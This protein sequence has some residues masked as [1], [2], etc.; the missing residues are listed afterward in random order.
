MNQLD[1]E[2]IARG[3][4][5][6]PFNGSA[7]GVFQPLRENFSLLPPVQTPRRQTSNSEHGDSLWKSLEDNNKRGRTEG[8]KESQPDVRMQGAVHETG[9][10]LTNSLNPSGNTALQTQQRQ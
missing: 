5:D 8:N 7:N 3:D 10:H 2:L 1:E 4:L 9:E 6:D